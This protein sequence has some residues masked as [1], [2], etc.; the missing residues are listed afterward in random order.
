[1]GYLLDRQIDE[2]IGALRYRDTNTHN[3]HTHT[4]TYIHWISYEQVD[5]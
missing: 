1:M 5:R 2:L 4:H 3:T